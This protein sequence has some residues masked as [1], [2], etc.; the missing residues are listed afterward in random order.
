MSGSVSSLQVAVIIHN[1]CITSRYDEVFKRYPF[2]FV[3]KI[4][5]KSPSI[6]D[7]E[8][9]NLILHTEQTSVNKMYCKRLVRNQIK[10]KSVWM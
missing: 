4:R 8:C 5:D 2:F 10:V 7:A 3:I 6:R 9:R 1:Y